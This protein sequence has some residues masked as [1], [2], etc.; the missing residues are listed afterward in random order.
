MHTP[1][2][3]PATGTG[4]QVCECGATRRIEAGVIKGGWH[5]CK[6]CVVTPCGEQP[7]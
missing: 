2:H 5:V 4:F 6:L 7:R 1:K 3:T